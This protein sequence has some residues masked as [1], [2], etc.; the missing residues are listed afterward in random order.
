MITGTEYSVT[1]DMATAVSCW[2][3]ER[4]WQVKLRR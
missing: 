4:L 1:P 2:R 3:M